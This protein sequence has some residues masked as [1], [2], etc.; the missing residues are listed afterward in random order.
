MV[1]L[2]SCVEV[3]AVLG[4]VVGLADGDGVETGEGGP[5]GGDGGW[6]EGGGTVP[7]SA[8]V[9]AAEDGAPEGGAPEGGGGPVASP[10]VSPFP[11]PGWPAGCAVS[12]GAVVGF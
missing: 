12:G 6:F 1:G 8:P 11:G 5:A 7:G 9:G 3:G 4:A 10:V 2:G